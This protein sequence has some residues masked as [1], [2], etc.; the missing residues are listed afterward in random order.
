MIGKTGHGKSTVGNTLLKKNAFRVSP[1][2]GSETTKSKYAYSTRKTKRIVVVDTPGMFDTRNENSEAIDEKSRMEIIRA[3]ML[4]SPGFHAVIIVIKAGERFTKENQET[5]HMYHN[6]FGDD[7]WKYTFLLLTH[8]DLM[9]ADKV[10][11][12]EYLEK[13]NDDF[14]AVLCLCDDKC[15]P[16]GK[17]KAKTQ[18]KTV[19][20]GIKANVE[21]CC[22]GCIRNVL[23][24][25]LEKLLRIWKD[26]KFEISA[27]NLR[28]NS[29]RSVHETSEQ[30][31]VEDA[32]RLLTSELGDLASDELR[33]G[34]ENDIEERREMLSAEAEGEG[35]AFDF[36]VKAVWGNFSSLFESLYKKEKP[37]DT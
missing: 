16:I 26:N 6:L 37:S 22:G 5:I 18:A 33:E 19:I 8:W 23:F 20:D 32:L 15:Y 17:R 10:K 36:L 14:K 25:E 2:S 1:F 3:C 28:T 21:R 24:K 13:A 9:E 35:C 27:E 29:P 11:F 30:L 7:F 34:E 31:S 4:L 12:D